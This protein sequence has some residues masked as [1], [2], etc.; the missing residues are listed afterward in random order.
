MA[1]PTARDLHASRPLSNIS[2]AF[3]QSTTEF[4][5]DRVFPN[6]PVEFQSNDYYVYNR[7]DWNRPSAKPRA[8]STQSAGG[9]WDVSTEAYNCDR[10]AFHKDIDDQDRANQD[11]VFNLDRETTEFV[12]RQLLLTREQRFVSSFF[13]T[14][15]WG[16]DITGVSASPTAGQVLQWDQAGSTPI[17]D[18]KDAALAQ[19]KATGF[20]PNTLVLGPEVLRVLEDHADIHDRIKYT[21]RAIVTTDLLASLFDVPRVLVPY[22]IQNTAKEGA[23]E[24]NSFFYGKSALLAYAAP[25]PGLMTPS[26]GYTFNWR[27]YLGS[28]GLTALTRRFRMEEITSDRIESEMYFDMKVVASEMGT[29]FASIT[30]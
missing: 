8:R 24:S 20:K 3:M 10:F 16:T 2:V 22:P 12:A 7:A 14:G 4:I 29:Y 5:A 11:D 17:Q 26:A 25:N 15:L 6:V 30:A 27:R 13:G 28:S 1:G 21:E 18:V 9:G 23:T 19:T